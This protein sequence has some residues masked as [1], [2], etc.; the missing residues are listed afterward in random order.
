MARSAAADADAADLRRQLGLAREAG[1]ELA[2]RSGALLRTAN[3]LVRLNRQCCKLAQELSKGR[4]LHPGSPSGCIASHLSI[5]SQ[6]LLQP[7][8]S[9]T[10]PSR[11]KQIACSGFLGAGT[12]Q[13][14]RGL[15]Q[16]ATPVTAQAKPAA[17]P[18]LTALPS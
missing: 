17:G 8:L 12:R 11:A 9:T 4:I 13:R 6:A 15:Q 7:C 2:Q 14:M 5:A 3:G 16:A 18:G 10:G 1:A